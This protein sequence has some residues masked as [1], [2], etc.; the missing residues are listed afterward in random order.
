MDKINEFLKKNYHGRKTRGLYSV[1]EIPEATKRIECNDGFS[2]SVQANDFTY[3]APRKN[4]A[5]PY[6]KVELGFPSEVD[7]IIEE[8]SEEPGT[9]K[10]VYPYVPIG[11][12]NQLIEK[13]GG[14]AN[15]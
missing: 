14:I 3:C 8:Y 2:I 5:W 4:K 9:T 10:T 12:V 15:L 6:S 7:D 11:I 1:G 13:H